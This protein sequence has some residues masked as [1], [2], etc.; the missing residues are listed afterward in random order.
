[1][2]LSIL[3]KLHRWLG[4]FFGLWLVLVALTGTLLLYK[5]ELLQWSYP[6]LKLQQIPTQATAAEVFD[7]YQEGYA[8]L[9]RDANPWLEIVMPSGVRHY[10]NDQGEHILARPY[11]GDWISV[12]VEF[13][14]HVLLHDLGKDLLGYLG[15]AGLILLIT[16]L[17][18]WWPRHWS[19]RLLSVR[20][21]WPWQRGFAA[22][23][24]QL[25]KVVG[26]LLFLP[27]LVG[28][29][30]GTAIMYAAAVS[31]GL[32]ALWPS[33]QQQ[34]ITA[35]QWRTVA[36]AHSWQQRFE[37]AQQLLPEHQ[38]RLVSLSNLS[39]RLTFPGEWHPNGR[40][41]VQFDANTGA[42][43]SVYDLRYDS[44]GYQ[45]SQLI[46]PVHIAAVGGLGWFI[47]V[48]MGGLA[49]VLLPLTGI[50]FWGWRQFKQR[51]R[52]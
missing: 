22:T 4:L 9:P 28:I 42:V 25:H 8:Y 36:A 46:F 5:V 35:D 14:H 52:R 51:V 2:V 19:R 20:W 10:Y 47:V 7:R 32:T 34:P 30:T 17:I 27:L 48:L 24:F 29:L 39:M 31:S 33:Q 18:R 11:L 43:T 37:R 26:S 1:M 6:Q 12:M 41:H 50:Y 21:V 49:L 40:S 16:G 13:H 45:V 3:I 38:P 44:R 15:I 23:L